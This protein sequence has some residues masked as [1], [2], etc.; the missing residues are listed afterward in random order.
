MN[1]MTARRDRAALAL[2][3]IYALRM[4]GL[5]LSFRC[6]PST[7]ATCRVDS[8]ARRPGLGRLRPFPGHLADPVRRPV[9]H[10][11]GRKPLITIGLILFALGSV[12]AALAH[13]I[14]GVILG[15]ALQGSGAIAGPVMALAADLSREEHRTKVMAMI[16]ISIG[17]S[18]AVAYR[19][20]SGLNHLMGVPGIFWLIAG[21]RPWRMGVLILACPN[22][23]T[24]P[25]TATPR[26]CRAS[27]KRPA[28]CQLSAP[29]LRHPG[30][31]R[32]SHRH[33]VPPLALH[34]RAAGRAALADLPAGA[35]AVDGGHGAVH[36]AAPNVPASA[37]LPSGRPTGERER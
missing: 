8:G 4:L 14:R 3:S 34:D 36:H 28:R 2:T 31:A 29:G 21:L 12:V 30:A 20:R 6:S 5:F 16:G 11:F 35:G 26:R 7:R 27:S 24:A 23:L 17:M 1:A 33:F 22:R 13:T 37:A 18:F 32:H 9:L 25:C 19:R 10:R 15:R